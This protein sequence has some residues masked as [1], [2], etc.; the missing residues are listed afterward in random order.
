MVNNTSFLRR[1]ISSDAIVTAAMALSLVVAAQ[2]LAALF[3]VPTRLLAIVGLLLLPFA[4]WV[5]WLARQKSPPAK[6][7]WLLV[8]AN[9]VWVVDSFLLL[10]SGSLPLTTLGTEFVAAQALLTIGITTLEFV[11][12]KR[13]ATAVA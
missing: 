2:P 3:G 11:A 8:V 6:L 1:V 9:V 5:G 10:L 4:A 12:I 7:V 13:S